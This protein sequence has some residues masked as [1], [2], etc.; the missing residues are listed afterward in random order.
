MLALTLYMNKFA[1]TLFLYSMPAL[2]TS[3]FYPPVYPLE[4]LEQCIEG[5]VV[6]EFILKNESEL[7]SYTVIESEPVD[8]FD[9]ASIKELKKYFKSYAE[10]KRPGELI[11]Q[12]FNFEIEG[13]CTP[14]S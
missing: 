9:Q 2:S 11:T 4:A 12:K 14:K 3:V 6:I 1:I 5:H 10:N 8:V 7:E 13:E